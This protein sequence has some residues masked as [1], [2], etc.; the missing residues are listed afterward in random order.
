MHIHISEIKIKNRIRETEVIKAGDIISL[1]ISI[2]IIAT[3]IYQ[4]PDVCKACCYI[5][6]ISNST[7]AS[8]VNATP[9]NYLMPHL[10]YF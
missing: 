6:K 4:L 8:R 3:N 5:P 10:T 7:L 1:Q 2:S 9:F